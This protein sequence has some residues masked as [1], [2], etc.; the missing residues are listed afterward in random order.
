MRRLIEI[1]SIFFVLGIL[2]NSAQVEAK[3]GPCATTLDIVAKHLTAEQF[4]ILTNPVVRPVKGGRLSNVAYEAIG[5]LREISALQRK[6]PIIFGRPIWLRF[7][8]DIG[9]TSDFFGEEKIRERMYNRTKK[10]VWNYIQDVRYGT[11]EEAAKAVIALRV[12]IPNANP[13][14]SLDEVLSADQV[15][16]FKKLILEAHKKLEAQYSYHTDRAIAEYFGV[17]EDQIF[18]FRD[19][20]GIKLSN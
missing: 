15:K 1:F 16:A 20:N 5:Q 4:D 8:D 17:S 12:M 10:A 9:L 7:T 13:K 2:G 19:R 18:E 6:R 14:K 11:D 3:R